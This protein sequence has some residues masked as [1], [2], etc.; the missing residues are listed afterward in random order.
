MTVGELRVRMDSRELTEW[1]AYTKYFVPI[2]NPWLQTGLIT[3]WLKLPYRDKSDPP[4]KATDDV[5]A[6]RPPQH[7]EQDRAAL[8]RLAAEL[9][10][11]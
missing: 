2:P 7:A 8:R 11:W 5:P 10:G 4:P 9:E 6:L 1:M 3:Q